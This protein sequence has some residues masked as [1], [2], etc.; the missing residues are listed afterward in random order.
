M[1]TQGHQLN[2]DCE[3]N[4]DRP[5]CDLVRD[6]L[7]GKEARGAETVGTGDGG[8]VREAGGESGGTCLVGGKTVVDVAAADI[9]DEGWFDVGAG[10]CVL[11]RINL[12]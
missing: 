8:R 4:F 5:A 7:N 9:F 12:K 11:G 10:E 1:G 2:A 3:T 6:L